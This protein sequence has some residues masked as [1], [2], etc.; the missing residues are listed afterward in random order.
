MC[1]TLFEVV[2]AF[3]SRQPF[4]SVLCD[5]MELLWQDSPMIEMERG[6]MQ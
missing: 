6:V 3:Y 4:P 1:E 5:V 2:C